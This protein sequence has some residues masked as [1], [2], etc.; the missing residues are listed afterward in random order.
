V[1]ALAYALI[2]KDST[3]AAIR[4]LH[5]EGIRIV[6]LTGDS[7]TTAR[8]VAGRLGIDEVIAEVQPDQKA[9]KV[10]EL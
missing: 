5:E 2:N 10:K 1:P 9:H 8:A 4:A 6:M 3:P 7:A